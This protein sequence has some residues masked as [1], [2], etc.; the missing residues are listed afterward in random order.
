MHPVSGLFVLIEEE[1]DDGSVCGMR[2]AGYCSL[3]AS[4]PVLL[5]LPHLIIKNHKFIGRGS[6]GPVMRIL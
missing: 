6:T 1:Y 3:G 5:N 2:M 4:S